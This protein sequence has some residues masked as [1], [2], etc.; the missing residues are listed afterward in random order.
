MALTGNLLPSVQTEHLLNASGQ[1]INDDGIQTT[2]R[3]AVDPSSN[4][5][6]GKSLLFAEPSDV[7]R[8]TSDWNR[9]ARVG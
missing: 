5:P 7:L 8:F 2:I 3:P 4:S 9:G 6:K 1:L